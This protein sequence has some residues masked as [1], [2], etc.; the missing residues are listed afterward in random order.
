MP[1]INNMKKILV[2]LFMLLSF[3]AANAQW[4]KTN[5]PVG[6]GSSFFCAVKDTTLFAFSYAGEVYGSNNLGNNWGIIKKDW[7]NIIGI[8][9]FEVISDTILISTKGDSY[10]SIDGG[11]FLSTD[12]GETWKS[13]TS[14]TFSKSIND[15]Y[16]DGT[17]LFIASDNGVYLSTNF[18]EKWI[19]K[20]EGGV[21]SRPLSI[22]VHDKY[23][24]VGAMDGIYI[25]TDFGENWTEKSNGLPSNINY[26]Y[27]VKLA[28]NDS[29]VFALTGISSHQPLLFRSTNYGENWEDISTGK[30][31][32]VIGENFTIHNSKIYCWTE[33]A[34][35][36]S[37]D[38]GDTWEII[39]TELAQNSS[40]V[41]LAFDGNNYWV[42]TANNGV[43]LSTDEGKSWIQRNN[44]INTSTVYGLAINGNNMYAGNRE[45]IISLTKDNGETWTNINNGLPD[46]AGMKTIVVD[47]DYIFAVQVGGNTI[48]MSPDN[49]KTWGI[50]PS[51]FPGAL[52][53]D[54]LIMNGNLVTSS[55]TGAF[56]SSDKGE[57]WVKS[58]LDDTTTK[59]LEFAIDG[60]KIYASS[61]SGVFISN[62][63]GFNWSRID[64]NKWNISAIAINDGN[65]YIARNRRLFVKNKNSENWDTLATYITNND[66][67][68]ILFYKN[69]MLVYTP[70]EDGLLISTDSGVSWNKR[71][72]GLPSFQIWDLKIKDDEI[73]A[74]INGAGIYKAKLEDIITDVREENAKLEHCTAYL[75]YTNTYPIPASD[76]VRSTVYWNSVYNIMDAQID[77]YNM[78]GI[79]QNNPEISI[80]K[81]ADYKANI[82][83]NCSGYSS[84]VYFIRVT[85]GG[86][87]M[88]VPVLINRGN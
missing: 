68:Q 65:I 58:A 28:S 14:G 27:I 30:I 77:I 39:N 75:Q 55:I 46:N 86:E 35:Y 57:S 43:F 53:Y 76:I 63:N 9:K 74:A 87:T 37:S 82:V 81:Q 8:S 64:T 1:I 40:I 36:M 23:I 54:M 44:G 60:D 67:N 29:I 88:A 78:Y 80:E 19:H 85:L 61:G 24:F 48:Y 26:G 18:G 6:V 47:S 15:F 11:I 66:I 79:K 49:G 32:G 59:L 12:N 69:N 70:R 10:N 62:N 22:L 45:N 34:I 84:G 16:L 25:S 71:N 51:S 83:W 17:N 20:K 7:E 31:D 2:I 41:N 72:G 38:N 52:I 5:G 21:Y 56:V 4:Q 13:I 33:K 50:T 3:I 42:G 73:Y